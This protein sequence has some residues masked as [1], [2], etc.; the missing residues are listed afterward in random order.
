MFYENKIVL[1]Q[2]T[3]ISKVSESSTCL[4]YLVYLFSY[5]NLIDHTKIDIVIL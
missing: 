3:F 5:N 1:C 4:F 2:V